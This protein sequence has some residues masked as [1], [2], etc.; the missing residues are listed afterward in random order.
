MIRTVLGIHQGLAGTISPPAC[1]SNIMDSHCPDSVRLAYHTLL[2][3]L[4]QIL[5]RLLFGCWAK[6]ITNVLETGSPTHRALVMG[7]PFHLGTRR[8]NQD[9]NWGQIEDISCPFCWSSKRHHVKPHDIMTPPTRQHRRMTVL[10]MRVSPRL[11][12]WVSIWTKRTCCPS[13][14]TC[15]LYLAEITMTVLLDLLV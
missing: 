5:D 9:G 14:A 6:P 13:T 15:M 10:M 12:R 3:V 4:N 2:A 11:Q 1:P 8:R 7:P